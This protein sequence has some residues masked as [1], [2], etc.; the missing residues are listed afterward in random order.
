M[1]VEEAVEKASA[2]K[3][4]GLTELHIV[5]GLHPDA[6]VEVLPAGAARAEGGAARRRAQVLHR[7]RG[8]LLRGDLRPARRRDPRRAHRRRPRVAHRRR[9]RDLRLGRPQADRRPQHA[10]GGLVAHPPAG[11]PEGPAHAGDDALRAHRGAPAP[12]R[13]RAAPARTAGRDRRLPGVHPA[14][15]PQRQQPALAPADGPAGRRAQDL[16]GVAG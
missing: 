14:A 5:N 15:L 4:D 2:M 13:P 16:R 1:R 11:P 9:R 12:R 7:H 8:A 10:L 6:A 3:D